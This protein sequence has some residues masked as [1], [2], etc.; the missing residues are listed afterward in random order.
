[1]GGQGKTLPNRLIYMKKNKYLFLYAASIFH[2]IDSW[3]FR[4]KPGYLDQ[5]E[6]LLKKKETML[7]TDLT[8]KHSDI[9][10][11]TLGPHNKCILIKKIKFQIAA[12]YLRRYIGRSQAFREFIASTTLLSIKVR[13]PTPISYGVNLSPFGQYESLYVNEY[14]ENSINGVEFLIEEKGI[15]ERN[16]FLSAVAQDLATI[17]NNGFF[18]KDS[19]FGNILCKFVDPTKIFW[20]DND[21]KKIKSPRN[22]YERVALGRFQKILRSDII[23]FNEWYF[24]IENYFSNLKK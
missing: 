1:M 13:C 6:S 10:T 17:H 22:K 7:G 18:H 19:H 5:I 23:S 4:V 16:S 14:I 8:Q 12:D 11:L 15:E 20:I 3:I 24:F 9:S 2:N 21:L